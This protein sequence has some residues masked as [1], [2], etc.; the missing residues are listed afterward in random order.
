MVREQDAKAFSISS[1]TTSRMTAIAANAILSAVKRTTGPERKRIKEIEML[2][3]F[4]E[5][6]FFLSVPSASLQQGPFGV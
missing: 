1:Y 5:C 4:I 6:I 2:H 3:C